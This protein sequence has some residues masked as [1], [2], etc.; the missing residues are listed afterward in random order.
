MRA[1][2]AVTSAICAAEPGDVLGVRG[3]FG[4]AWPLAEAEGRDVVVVAGGIGLAP[5]RPV[6]HELLAHRD[7]YGERVGPLRRALAGRACST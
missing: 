5:L 4:T 2:G 1:V 6:V 3:P 7:R